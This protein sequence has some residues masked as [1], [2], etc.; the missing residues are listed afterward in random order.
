MQIFPCNKLCLISMFVILQ[1]YRSGEYLFQIIG[2]DMHLIWIGF[3]ANQLVKYQKNAV[4]MLS[5]KEF[6]YVFKSELN[7]F[8]YFPNRISL[9][10]SLLVPV[11]TYSTYLYWLIFLMKYGYVFSLYQSNLVKINTVL[12]PGSQKNQS[13][14]GTAVKIY[15]P[16]AAPFNYR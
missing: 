14:K 11:R 13:T 9:V 2:L 12:C 15:N 5:T 16:P 1:A 8:F 10:F 4:R 6:P 7:L 3:C